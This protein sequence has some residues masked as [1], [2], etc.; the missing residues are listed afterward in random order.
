MGTQVK[1][2]GIGHKKQQ[3]KDTLARSIQDFL[4]LSWVGSDI[5]PFALPLKILA[6][7]AFGLTQNQCWGSDSEKDTLTEVTLYDLGKDTRQSLDHLSARRVLQ[8]TGVRMRECFPGIWCN[9]PFRREYSEDTEYVLIPDV[10]F[11]DEAEKILSAGGDLIRIT[12]PGH[13]LDDDHES[14]HALDGFD[15]WT[16]TVI[17]DGDLT[18]MT[19]MG[20]EIALR[21]G[22]EGTVNSQ[23]NTELILRTSTNSISRKSNPRK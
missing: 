15:R 2:I 22:S 13:V 14:E 23:E 11:P 7:D 8:E 4:D 5:I 6:Q 19:R 1:F 12:R 16:A 21:L 9:A 20:M 18:D 3:G 17:N 10:R